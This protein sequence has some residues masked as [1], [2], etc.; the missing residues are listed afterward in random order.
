MD[1]FSHS[2]NDGVPAVV[3]GAGGQLGD[4]VGRRVALD[5]AQLAEVVDG[6]RGV[7]GA[8]ADADDEQSSAALAQAG[9]T[10][11][12]RVDLS[13]VDRP[14]DLGGGLEVMVGVLAGSHSHSV[15]MIRPAMLRAR[16]WAWLVHVLMGCLALPFIVHQNAWF[17]WSDTLWLLELQTAHV[18]A[19]G[20]P[21]FFTHAAGLYFY[22]QQ[23][24]YAGPWIS[25]LA[26]PSAILGAWPVFA[27]A[28]AASFAAASAGIAW[29]ARNLGVPGRWALVPGTLFVT[30]PYLVSDLYGRGAWAEIIA[31][32]ALAVATGAATSLLCARA[33]SRCAVTAVLA[34]AV[35][36][37]AGTHNLTLLFSALIAPLLAIALAPM[38]GGSISELLSR[39]GW[40]LAGALIG[41]A[42][43][44]AFLVPDVWLSGRTM[45]NDL[46]AQ[47][48]REING[49]DQIGVIFN[50]R[51][52]RPPGVGGSDVFTQT[53]ALALYWC[54]PA[55][56]LLAIRRSLDRRR[57][58]ALVLLGLGVVG[59]SVLITNPGW[60]TSF[61]AALQAIQFPFRLV[62]YLTL[63]IVLGVTILLASPALRESRPAIGAIA[64]IAILQFTVA[65][66]VAITTP[67][68]GT[69]DAPTSH[70]VRA[71]TRPAAFAAAQVTGYRLKPVRPLRRPRAT[72]TVLGAVGVDT[73][74]RVRLSGDQPVGTLVATPVVASPLIGVTG[75]ASAA[76]S[77]RD[78]LLVLRAERSPWR[79]EVSSRA[80][81]AVV[82]GRITSLLAGLALVGLLI[83]A[84]AGRARPAIGGGGRRTARRSA[85]AGR[86]RRPRADGAGSHRRA[87]DPTAR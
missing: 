86:D 44:G 10:A 55:T 77:T 8:A 84:I 80:P 17:E 51:P 30:A 7:P 31:L 42:L 66:V 54:L 47:L 48:L 11:G 29:T 19:F 39:F 53:A 14:G 50:P 18:S 87:T 62:P 22:P 40:V 67:A 34:L 78:G 64:V 12:H 49:Y 56:T 74:P 23:L 33:R 16:Q 70:T 45:I 13:A 83:G 75:G 82:A 69:R 3:V 46:S 24:F 73:R 79:A 37:I 2:L 32:S 1:T 21:T 5:P 36:T 43:C 26:Y 57:V 59:L 41:V 9:Q 27:A 58:I 85:A 38:F 68:R 63:L 61:P 76:G 81:F 71:A 35:A 65:A 52:V 25:V 72:A 6:V 4:V 15:T 20:L 60:W 28:T